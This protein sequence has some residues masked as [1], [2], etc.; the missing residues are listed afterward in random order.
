MTES[1]LIAGGGI[2]GLS[3]AL[4]LA[5]AGVH[6]QVFERSDTFAEFGAGIQLGPNVMRVLQ[7]WGLD[8]GLAQVVAYPAR[9]QVMDAMSGE[10][11]AQL[12]LDGFA[13]RY[14]APYA[15]IHRADLHQLL[16]RTVRA[17]PEVQLH[18]GASVAQVSSTD[19]GVQA[20]L[21]DS[22]CINAATLVAADGAWSQLR[23]QCLGDGKPQ[24][25]GHLAYRALVRQDD[26][27][28]TLRTQHVTLWLG[29]RLHVVH[30]PV[31]AG[32][33]LNVV[34]IVHGRVLGDM[35]H[36]DHSANVADLQRAMAGVHA[37]LMQ[38][39][40]AIAAWRLWPLSVRPPMRGA[41]E[42]VRGR[43]ALLGDAAHPMVPYLAQGAA[44][45]IEDAQALAQTLGPVL[46]RAQQG[47]APGAV[48]AALAQY[49]EQRWARDARVQSRALRNGRIF[50]WSGAA[51]V[52]RNLALRSLGGSLLDQTWL[53]DAA[54]AVQR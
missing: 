23:Q 45:A 48:E 22:R 16:A 26:L 24:P 9:L 31:R 35:A 42:M 10:Q 18:L 8:S 2:G 34:A 52:A 15:T 3:A 53:Y 40:Q 4:A 1:V 5:Q 36:W 21:A 27:P 30:Y 46:G 32:E 43:L 33:W 44:M 11:L 29:P 6:C 41:H 47:V 19:Q 20:Q 12:A 7:A 49:A 50:H 51:R 25:T 13:R 14:G 37:R 54:P 17:R 28:V 38:R 39:I